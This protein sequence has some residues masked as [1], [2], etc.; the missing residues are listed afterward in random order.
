MINAFDQYLK[1]TGLSVFQPLRSKSQLSSY[2]ISYYVRNHIKTW[3][4]LNFIGKNV[5]YFNM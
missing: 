2:V 1:I 5:V 3:L 4:S